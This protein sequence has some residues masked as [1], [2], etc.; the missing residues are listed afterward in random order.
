MAYMAFIKAKGVSGREG[1]SQHPSTEKPLLGGARNRT[2]F[3]GK[4]EMFLSH[5]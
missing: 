4:I 3:S 1:G 2:D 5:P